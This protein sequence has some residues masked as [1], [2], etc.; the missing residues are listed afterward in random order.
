MATQTHRLDLLRFTGGF[1]AKKIE[2]GWNGEWPPPLM[3]GVAVG[4]QTGIVKVFDPRMQPRSLMIQLSR[5]DTIDFDVFRRMS[6][7]QMP[8]SEG[9][10]RGASYRPANRSLNALGP[11]A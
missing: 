10:I 1:I 3:M 5:C 9:I 2:V 7:S 11:F 4:K 8:P 6:Y